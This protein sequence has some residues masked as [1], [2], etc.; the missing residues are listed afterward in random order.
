MVNLRGTSMISYS[1]NWMGPISSDWY[2]ERGLAQTKTIPASEFIASITDMQVGEEMEYTEVTTYYSGG[3]IDIYGLPDDEYYAGK[4]EY[5]LSIMHGE[6]W[7]RLSDWL[8]AFET[9]ELMPYDELIDTFEAET[10]YKI[11]WAEEL[12]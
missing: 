1:T 7:N 8:G 12:E 11:R 5:G 6:D 4:S 9:E 10:G 2:K 3:R